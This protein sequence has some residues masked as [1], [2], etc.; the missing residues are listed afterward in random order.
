[1]WRKC[2]RGT[3][4]KVRGA[5]ISPARPDHVLSEPIC[6][7]VDTITVSFFLTFLSHSLAIIII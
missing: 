3:G 5:V 1:M 4:R 7:L 6:Y 2:G